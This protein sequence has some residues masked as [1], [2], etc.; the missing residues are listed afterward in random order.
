M[1]MDGM[2]GMGGAG[3]TPAG[4]FTL[5]STAF[6][7]GDELP[8]EFT[9]EGK[10]FSTGPIPDLSWTA[11]PEGTLSYAITFIDLTL[12]PDQNAY[13]WAM[14]DIPPDVTSLPGGEISGAE[15]AEPAGSK[16]YTPLNPVG[17]LGPCPG[18]VGPNTDEYAF[19]VYAL[20]VESIPNPPNNVKELEQL[21][22]ES[23]LAT[24]EMRCFSDAAP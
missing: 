18:L 7:D 24:T 10:Q 19:V 20:S 11:G 2:L 21:F 17:F 1:D 22:L 5:T 12:S 14:W 9:C 4:E 15:P 6:S 13:H 3:E 8:D 16:Q 23:A